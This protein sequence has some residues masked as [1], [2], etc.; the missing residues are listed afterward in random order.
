MCLTSA[1]KQLS[2]DCSISLTLHDGNDT[3]SPIIAKF[4]STDHPPRAAAN[5][6]FTTSASQLTIWLRGRRRTPTT[7]PPS[8]AQLPPAPRQLPPRMSFVAEFA[9]V[10]STASS[11]SSFSSSSGVSS[12]SERPYADSRL[13]LHANDNDNASKD[14]AIQYDTVFTIRVASLIYLTRPKQKIDENRN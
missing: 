12:S 9:F 10:D 4:C 7:T 1:G 6:N 3:T 11:S 2:E 13:Q 5:L 14:H 8:T